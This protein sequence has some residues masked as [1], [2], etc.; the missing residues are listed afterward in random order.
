[1]NKIIMSPGKY[2]QANNALSNLHTYVQHFG[3]KF[4]VITSES[5]KKRSGAQIES[6][7]KGTDKTISFALFNKECSKKEIQQLKEACIAAGCDCI[8]G[9]GGGK[10][11]DTAKAVAHYLKLAVVIIP[12]I[13]STDAPCSALSVIYH[14]NGVFE[15]Y[16]V[17]PKNPELVIMDLDVIAASP[18]RFLVAGMGDA[19]ATYFE[20]RA[21][22]ASNAT[23]MAGLLPAKSAFALAELCYE[24]LLADGYKAKLAA[25][26]NVI[27]Q[28]FENIVEAN[29]YLSGIGFESGGLAAAHAIHNGFTVLSE[30]H[31]LN[32][33]E[34]VA[35]GTLTQLVLEN[36]DLDEIEEVLSFC[37]SVGL[38]VTLEQMGVK[39]IDPKMIL[40][41]AEL[42]TA[43][44]ETIH[45]MPF[46]VT[47]KDVYAAIMTADALGRAFLQKSMD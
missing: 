31:H 28:A 23:N 32:H 46:K 19:L 45:N 7:F 12:T 47:S 18:S 29:T 41:V 42:A 36:A 3:S 40:K 20:A 43:E 13:A 11:L 17:L 26:H 1:M 30:C 5:G 39:Q 9:V 37:R 8:I 14:E 4:F 10:L 6:S 24:T 34:K 25:E 21:A 16:L 38:P 35:F 33:G 22:R 2:I 15:E 44:G 27:T